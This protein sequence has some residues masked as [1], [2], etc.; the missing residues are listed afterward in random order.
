M[1]DQIRLTDDL[2]R[3]A[4]TPT[5]D[6]G[7]AE[8]QLAVRTAVVSTRQRRYWWTPLRPLTGPLGPSRELRALAIAAVLA[9]LLLV[10]AAVFGTRPA[11]PFIGDGSMFHGGPSR[12][13]EVRA[14]GPVGP[15]V[16]LWTVTLD[17]PLVNA[18]PV[19]DG[20]RLFVA[21][22]QG[23]VT[24]YDSLTGSR[25]WS[26]RLPKPATSPALADGVLVLGAGDGIYGLDATTGVTLWHQQ[27][28]AAVTSSPAVTQGVVYAGLPS[29]EVAAFELRTGRPIWRQPIGGAV[30]RSPALAGGVFYGG[31][32]GT[33]SA[34]DAA[35]GRILWT[36]ELGP[37]QTATPAI[38]DGLVYVTSG[39]DSNAA[40]HRLFVLDAA[41]GTDRWTF[42]APSGATLYVGAVGRELAYVVSQD[43]HVYALRSGGV[44]GW[45]YDAGAAIGS[46][47]TLSHGT[48]Y[49]GTS[50]GAL[51]ALDATTGDVRWRESMDGD[52]GP[53]VVS[54][55]ILWA[56]TNLGELRAYGERPPPSGG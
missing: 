18:M 49:V 11:D 56:G 42:E 29:G 48:L 52:V 31:G 34:L 37:G 15:V 3:A 1:S 26:Q 9:A 22:G 25:G 53:P 43:G 39:L 23:H 20:G 28:D 5:G 13:G 2:I 46:V 6:G 51:I 27:T 33:F 44:L 14:S 54:G 38:R 19:L 17:G 4:L 10:A 8:V 21:D 30:E 47:A 55:G 35:T 40:P 12:T 24:L 41:S 45:T 50:G 32:G 16:S 36:R 7:L